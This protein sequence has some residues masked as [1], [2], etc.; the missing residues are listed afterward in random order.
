MTT[1]SKK[2]RFWLLV[3]TGET[4]AFENDDVKHSLA[5]IYVFRRFNVDDR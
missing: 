5:S 4:A 2:Y 3:G 1:T